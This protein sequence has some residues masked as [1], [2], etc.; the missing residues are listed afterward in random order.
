MG[1]SAQD[2][3]I[4][5]GY[6]HSTTKKPKHKIKTKPTLSSKK[7]FSTLSVCLTLVLV[8]N[9]LFC[10]TFLNGNE[11]V[12]VK[13]YYSP[14]LDKNPT[15]T[16]DN[17]ILITNNL[18]Y[19][20]Q[21]GVSINKIQKII[22]GNRRI[23]GYKLAVWNCSRGLIQD[24]FSTKLVEIKQFINTRRPHCFGI[25]E[26]DLFNHQSQANRH[27]KY[28][29]SE[30]REKLKIDGYNIEFPSSWYTHGQARLICYVL[31][32]IKY[33]RKHLND[34]LEHI[35]SITLEV[36]QGKATKTTVHYYYREWT[37]GVTG[38]SD[39]ASQ[40]VQLQ[41]HVGQWEALVRSGRKF[42]SLGDANVCAMHW[43]D[44]NFRN[45]NLSTQIQTFLLRESC[46]QLVNKY[47]R[48]QSV[49]GVLQRSCIDHVTTNVPEKCSV[50]EVF[51]SGSSDHMPVM[52]T[53]FSREPKT[54][55]KTIKKR[56]YKNFNI[57]NFLNEVQEHVQNGSF[58][59]V[60]NNNN[61]D[62]ASALF[63]GIF[64]SI[65]NKHAPL[66][67]F[68][69][70]NN[71]V[72]WISEETKQMQAARDA[73]KE[74]A[75][76]ENCNEKHEAFKR[77]RNRIT[78][79]LEKDH[80]NHYENKFY[81]E[82]PS[83]STLWNN[84]NDYLNTSKR[85]FSNTPNIISYN[86]KIHT[87]PRDIA[88]ALNDA[89]LQKVQDL[90]AKVDGNTEID[91]KERLQKFLDKREDEI[92][93][94]S[95]KKISKQKLRK[96]LKKRKGNRSCGIDYIDGYSIKLAAPLI[97][98]ILLHLVNLSI[99]TSLFPS[100]WK[101]N[102]VSPQ[103]KKGDK[104]LGE[105]WRPVTDIVFVSKLAEAAVYEQVEGHFT[106]SKLWHP[107]HHGFKANHSTATAINQIYDFCWIR[108]AEKT[109]LTAALLLDLSATFDVVDHQILL[110]KLKLYN[111]S[112]QAISWFR[113]YL[114]G[115]KQVV[116]IESKTSDPKEVGEQGVPQGSLLGPILFI[117]FYNDFPEVRE[118]G[119][120]VIYADDDTD[121]VSDK[122]P[123]SLQQKIQR[124]AN[125]STS[126]VK[127]N[128]LVCSGSKTKLLIVGTKE[129][130]KSKLT[131]RDIS[132][133]IIVDGHPVKETQSERLL[134]VLVNNVLTWEHH[135]YGN[136]EHTGLIQKLSHRARII[137][138]LSLVM[139]KKNLKMMAEGIFFSLL[140]YCIEVYG[141][142]WGLATYDDHSR[143]STA[144]TKDDNAKLQILVNKVLRSLTGLDRDTPIVTLHATSG[145]LSVQQRTA[146][147]T[148]VSVHKSIQKKQPAYNYSRLQP[149]SALVDVRRIDYKLSLS[150]GSFYYRGSKLYSQLP[151]NLTQQVNQAAF[152]KG[153]K[154]WVSENIPVQPP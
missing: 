100:L 60:T 134:G 47:T 1:I 101:V 74:E 104:T 76:E 43:N 16:S 18:F 116:V 55:P 113:S 9:F 45:K 77:L 86:N 97:E 3:R 135:L 22:N 26:S 52:V 32:E 63:S 129:L 20:S 24:D 150:R 123:I 70:R 83:T 126:W 133:E 127:D 62:E 103:F 80:I 13:K 27:R 111:F 50:P 17:Q 41:Q 15:K 23:I 106:R 88:N 89:F 65:L 124:E 12:F 48:V 19:W 35:P 79:K 121:N 112:P 30:I 42:I 92:P 61:I 153:A 75:I 91:P 90:R 139:P 64:G 140:N 68:Q 54:Q 31:D 36:G 38:E 118:E 39:N 137:W 152:K 81:Q 56:N 6:F 8:L 46:S 125:L 49:S 131:N 40:L 5:I 93:E 7:M 105:N 147:F 69:V 57:P 148:I 84:A 132:I 130:R 25:I 34:G 120:S 53:K 141:N 128:K 144:F 73:L 98:D 94:F 146:M 67:V 115:R 142:V 114:Q 107:N 78:G 28:S 29:S 117:I 143:K 102:K 37:N 136:E 44:P 154:K 85:S 71:Y 96:L 151:A 59:R 58:D 33:R 145:Q 110:D 4:R 122:D 82:N 95:I 99:E 2:F 11:P 119:T 149:N 21:S 51:T 66:K 72:P 109:E 138:K 10:Q 87:K 14:N 108:S